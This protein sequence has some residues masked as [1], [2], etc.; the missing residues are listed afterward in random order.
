MLSRISTRTRRTKIFVL[1]VLMLMLCA[2][3]LPCACAYACVVGVLTT[4]M[5]ILVLVLMSQWKPGSTDVSHVVTGA[6]GI[7][8]WF[9]SQC[10]LVTDFSSKSSNGELSHSLEG[11]N[12]KPKEHQLAIAVCGLKICTLEAPLFAIWRNLIALNQDK[13]RGKKDS[14]S[15]RPYS[16]GNYS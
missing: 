10:R 12:S 2:S 8:I 6:I 7:Q 1:L 15:N 14:P 16:Q 11:V 4:V 13:M 3:S 5:L 9:P